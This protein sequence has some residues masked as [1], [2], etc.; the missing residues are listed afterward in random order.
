MFEIPISEIQP[1][2]QDQ[3]GPDQAQQNIVDQTAQFI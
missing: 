1:M 3:Q 2:F